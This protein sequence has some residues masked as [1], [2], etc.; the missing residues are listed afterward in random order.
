M[1]PTFFA[2][3]AALRGWLEKQHDQKLELW[4]G[5]HKKGSRKPS[6]TWPE[7][8]DEDL[9]FGWIDGVRKR[10]D[11]S[12]YVIRFTPRKRGSIWSSVNVKRV[13]E[14]TG[15]GRMRPEGIRAFEDRKESKSGIYSYEQKTDSRLAEEDEKWFRANRKAWEFFQAQAP[16][17]R[18]LMI[19]RVI[20]AKKVETRKKRLEAL[21]GESALGRRV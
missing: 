20:S 3:P 12:S 7:S 2:T 19:W 14:L 13:E 5:F 10:I 4:V 15:L 17:Y 8:V 9:C 11:D 21:I 18:R 1:K 6:I 16:S